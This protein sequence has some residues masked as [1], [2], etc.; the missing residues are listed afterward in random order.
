MESAEIARR[1]LSFFEQRG[2]VVVPSASLIAEDP[3]LLL[4]NAGMVPFKPYFLGQRQPPFQ[5]ATSAQKCVRTPDIDEVGKTTRHGT[6]FQMLGN[7]SFGDYFKE[8][9]IPFAWELLTSPE[10]AGGFGFAEDRLWATV[11]PDDD[12]AAKIWHEQVG[13]PAGPDPAPRPGRQLLAHGR[14][15]ARRPVLGDLLRPRPRVRPRGRPGRGRGPLPRGVEP[16][17]HAGDA[18]RGPHQGRLRRLGPAAVA[19]HRHRHGPGAD[20][21]AAAGRR[22]HLRDRHDVEGARPGGRAHRAE[23]RPR[24]PQRR[25]PAGGGR[26]R[27]HRGHAGRRRRGP[28]QRGPRLRAAPDPAP[29]HPQPAAAVRRAARRRWR[30]REPRR[31]RRALHARAVGRGDRRARRAVPRA[32]PRRAADPHGHRRRGVGVPRHAAHR[33]RDLRRGGRGDAAQ[34]RGD[35]QGQPGVPAARHLRLPDR[36]DPG[37]GR[38]A[39]PGGRRAGVPPADGRAARAGQGRRGGQEDR[40]RRHLGVR[41]DPRH[42]GPGRLHRLRRGGRRRDGD[43]AARRRGVG[44]LGRAG[45]RGRRGARPDAVLRRGRRPARRHRPDHGVGQ[46]RGRRRQ[47]R[48]ARRAD[49]RSRA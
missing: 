40:Q 6:F 46:R 49:A 4:V 31:R 1:F 44:A 41:A 26:P 38:G 9:A 22:Q 5:R 28:L 8:L 17:V 42:L 11:Y 29:Q 43:R 7:F 16:R 23:V 48:G 36:P 18:Q 3:T 12:E 25:L 47:G 34:G 21:G 24:A 35:D 39:G 10:S 13:L 19:Q 15:G 20:G 45:R 30:Q 2:H 32:D 37:D 27:P 14:A 33:H